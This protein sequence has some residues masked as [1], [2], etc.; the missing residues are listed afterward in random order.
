MSV[1]SLH[2]FFA[3]AAAQP[4]ATESRRK[5]K[6]AMAH[7][8]MH[9][10]QFTVDRSA[11]CSEYTWIDEATAQWATDHVDP[12][13]DQEDGFDKATPAVARTCEHLL[14]Y[15]TSDHFETMEKPSRQQSEA[16]R[17]YAGYLF[18]QYLARRY[19]ANTLRLLLDA[20]AGQASIEAM[21]SV[22]AAH[23]GMKAVWPDFAQTLWLN[24][25]DRV[26]DYWSGTDRYDY[27]LANLFDPAPGD[28]FAQS[29]TRQRTLPVDQR[30][31][32][33]A[34]FK[35]LDSALSSSSASY[36]VEPRSL[37]VEHLT[38]TD[39]AVRA[40]LLVNPIAILPNRDFMKLQ[41]V[42]KV[43]GVWQSVED[44]T[45]EPA[46]NFC[47]DKRDERLEELIL[48]VTNSE[49][50]RGAEQPFRIPNILPL[51]VSTSNVGCWRYGGMASTTTTYDDGNG[52]SGQIN[53]SAVVRWEVSAQ[54]PLAT[55]FEP[56]AGFADGGASGRLSGC[57]FT[58]VAN[59]KV[60]EGKGIPDGR[61]H[62]N[63]DLEFGIGEPP[64]RQVT[65]LD[66]ASTLQSTRTLVCPGTTVNSSGPSSFTWLQ[67]DSE[68]TYTISA[69]GQTVEGQYIASFPA[70]RSSITTRFK[71]TAERE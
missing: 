14:R 16:D 67:V 28:A 38:F 12:G 24:R 68:A 36:E 18:F 44:W 50:N 10:L 43:G 35:L 39:P 33:R 71:F 54:L 70:T 62:I 6:H 48:I 66:G 53:G 4:A 3:G 49:V 15:L 29:F 57:T 41:A 64:N 40:V 47:R 27:G 61:M 20:Q 46:K 23:G 63:L 52:T 30:G 22:L 1:N 65:T 9:A 21:A 26:L 51:R 34:T 2:S 69:D 58:D 55:Q 8:F 37:L 42:K 56:R 17:G 45:A 32:P 11:A 7:E 60:V 31:Q 25:A 5:V 19:T 59:R 13:Y